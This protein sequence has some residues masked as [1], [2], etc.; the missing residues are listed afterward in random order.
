MSGW[1]FGLNREPGLPEYEGREDRYGGDRRNDGVARAPAE[2]ARLDEAVH[3]HGQAATGED[4]AGQVDGRTVL[5]ARLRHEHGHGHQPDQHDRH[6]HQE[7]P[8]PPEVGEDVAT[9]DRP[10]RQSKEVTGGPDP[11]RPRPLGLREEDRDDRQRHDQ[12]RGAGHAEHG[13]RRDEGVGVRGIG[14]RDRRDAEQGNRADQDGLA[15]VAIAEKAGRQHARGKG[16]GVGGYEPLQLRFG[17]VE[18][19]G[20]RGQGQVQHGLVQA[21]GDQGERQGA[22]RQPSA[23]DPARAG[24]FKRHGRHRL[25]EL[26][27]GWQ[28][29]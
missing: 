15:A 9:H 6:V 3:Q 2:V 4:N 24:R 20:K 23:R 18:R 12:Q 29:L 13:A 17:G 26:N 1:A 10:E 8:A 16:K 25:S 19:V 27:V 5:A 14:A 11:H 22:H 21:D 7:D 28:Y